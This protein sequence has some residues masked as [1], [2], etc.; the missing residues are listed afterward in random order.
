MI[1]HKL[2]VAG[3][4]VVA[5]IHFEIRKY[6]DRFPETFEITREEFAPLLAL[7]FRVATTGEMDHLS[8]IGVVPTSERDMV[9][10]VGFFLR[11]NGSRLTCSI[12]GPVGLAKNR[13][14]RMAQDRRF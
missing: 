9:R 8:H 12:L 2:T 5:H 1:G 10:P 7:A 11:N 13:R 3:D 6:F 14:S 4:G